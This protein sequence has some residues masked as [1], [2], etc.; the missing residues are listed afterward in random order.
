MS[1]CLDLTGKEQK[2]AQNELESVLS[3]L[4]QEHNDEVEVVADFDLTALLPTLQQAHWGGFNWFPLE[5]GPSKWRASLTVVSPPI[6]PR[7]I[8]EFF[9]IDHKRCDALFIQVE[10]AAQAGKQEQSKQAFAEFLLGMNH[11]FAMEEELFF[12]AFEQATGMS[13]GPTLVMRMEHQQMRGLMVQMEGAVN[14]GDVEAISRVASTMMVI[15]RQHNIKEE[16]M[17]YRMGDMHL[18]DQSDQ[19]LRLAQAL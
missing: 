5:R 4:S 6:S 13:Q 16:Q 12:P 7:G 17:L 18:S 2:S 15:M 14:R 9:S 8:E 19:L 11:H 1:F 3:T 10:T